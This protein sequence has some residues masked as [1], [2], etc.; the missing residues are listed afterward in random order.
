MKTLGFIIF[1]VL[2]L[3]VV[4]MIRYVTRR[5]GTAADGLDAATIRPLLEKHVKFYQHLAPEKQA[6]FETRVL[7]FLKRVSVTGVGVTVSELDR[8]LVGA[9]AIIPIFA[10]PGWHYT[11][12]RE[13]LLYPE[14]FNA[15]FAQQGPDRDI[16]GM[17]GNGPLQQVMMLSRQALEHGFANT[18]DKRNTAIHEFVHLIDKT[19]GDTDGIPE[20]LLQ[21]QYS[22]PWIQLIRRCIQEIR[23]NHSDI[24][25]YGAT[26]E[27]EF[28][29]VVSEYFF[30]RPDLLKSRHPELY[31]M[32]E[33][34]FK[35]DPASQR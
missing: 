27:A 18:S 33:K 29:A 21:H 5:K 26:N 9:S 4:I 24:D 25:V 16:L 34:I 14:T 22:I 35:S 32:L 23:Q 10:F 28:F 19:D 6:E 8:V 1:V 31:A 7:D 30:E 17:V 20:A 11:N 2:L 12:L 15:D 13:I 3:L